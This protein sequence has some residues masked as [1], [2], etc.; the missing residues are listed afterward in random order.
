MRLARFSL[1][2]DACELAAVDRRTL[3]RGAVMVGA[4]LAGL[5][6]ASAQKVPDGNSRSARFAFTGCR[7]TKERNA[8]GEGINVFRLQPA[9]ASW[10]HI[11]LHQGLPNPSFLAC[12]RTRRFLYAVHGDLGDV[13]AHAI[14]GETGRVSLINQ[15]ST[16]GRNPVHLLVDATS[17]FLIIANYA[18]GSIA[19]LPTAIRWPMPTRTS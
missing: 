2:G 1:N 18:T 19:V 17:R 16:G 12:D 8:R 6:P 4:S 15:Q 5:L 9:A 14:D 7:T 10:E 11:Q 13:S 3:C